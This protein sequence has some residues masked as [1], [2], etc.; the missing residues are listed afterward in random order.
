[1]YL[2][3]PPQ[4][5]C[6]KILEALLILVCKCCAMYNSRRILIVRSSREK[7]DVSQPDEQTANSQVTYDWR[8]IYRPWY[9]SYYSAFGRIGHV[10]SYV[11]LSVIS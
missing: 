1:M 7:T 5:L 11:L 2:T 10:F 6:A 4:R 3:A 8:R 9:V